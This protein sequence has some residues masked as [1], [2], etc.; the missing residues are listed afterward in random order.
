MPRKIKV[1]L[2]QMRC[3]E[4]KSLNLK[5]AQAAVEEAAQKGSQIICLPE[6]FATPYF[7][8]EE[9]PQHF[10]WA[11]TLDGE[12]SQTFQALAAKLEVVLI[13]PI[14]EKRA[15]GLFHNTVLV[16]DADGKNLGIY[17]KNHIPD[18]PGFY[19]K[20]YFTPGDLGYPVFK[21]KYAHIGVLIC[22]DQWFPEAARLSSLQ[23]AELIF[24]PSAIGWEPGQP[25]SVQDEE[26]QAWQTIQRAHGIA[27][28]ISIISVNR[29]GKEPDT[30]FWGGSFVSNPF[31]SVLWQASHNQEEVAIQELELDQSDHYRTIWP[32]LRD[33]RIDTYAP[34]SKRY[35]DG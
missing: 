25:A 20:Y 32:F 14:F 12:T 33:R 8:R 26:Y 27:N 3:L 16:F 19:E 5:N 35:L 15:P 7:C 11:E 21:T 6:L 34:L 4:N 9:N 24:Y 29:I 30:H 13:V 17:R 1:G 28:G 22:W 31:G 23:G 2:I 10:Q 18:D